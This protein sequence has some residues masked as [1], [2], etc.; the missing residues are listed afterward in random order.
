MAKEI[1]KPHEICQSYYALRFHFDVKNKYDFFR[2]A[3]KVPSIRFDT[4][5]QQ[6]K[7]IKIYNKHKTDSFNYLLANIIEGRGMSYI[8]DIS[9]DP[10]SDEVYSEWLGFRQSMS[11][12]FEEKLKKLKDD[13][14]EFNKLLVT[15]GNVPALLTSFFRKEVPFEVVCIIADITKCID[16]WDKKI[17]DDVIYPKIRYKIQ[18]YIPFLEY[19]KKKIKNIIV[20]TFT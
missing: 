1:L 9:D 3:G 10:A 18:Q 8:G 13:Y 4:S 20:S 12:K 11:Y 15:D 6:R 19:D 2:Y 17:Q 14:G 16:M 5:K 7:F